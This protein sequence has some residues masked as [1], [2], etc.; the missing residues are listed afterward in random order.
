[1]I[2][3][4]NFIAFLVSYFLFLF[5]YLFSIQPMKRE[6]K[7]GEKA[8][9]ECKKIRMICGIFEMTTLITL[10]LWIPFPI[11]SLHWKI[12]D[13]YVPLIIITI[14]LMI[15]LTLI[16]T[17][18]IK[19]AGSETLMPSKETEMYGGIYEYIR[20]PQTLGEFPMFVAFALLTNTWFLVILNIIV[21]LIYT[22]IMVYF[23]EKD[24][25]L[26]F[27]DKYREYQ[28]RTGA[29]FPKFWNK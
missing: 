23:E 25:T 19:D 29:L 17:K 2:E 20:H 14:I 13:S 24:L 4:I 6:Q 27:G 3:W 1:M 11:D 28:K 18:G 22:P 26:R 7:R 9:E 16:M 8:W 15:P 12:A 21:I 10:L 5:L